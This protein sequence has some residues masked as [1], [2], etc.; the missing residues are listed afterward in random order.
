MLSQAGWF[1]AVNRISELRSEFPFCFVESGARLP[2]AHHCAPRGGAQ[3]ANALLRLAEATIATGDV[4]VSIG[5][6]A[7]AAAA[8]PDRSA[9]WAELARVMT[10]YQPADANLARQMRST[11]VSAAINAYQMSRSTNTRA[12]APVVMGVALEGSQIWRPA[13]S[14][15]RASLELREIPALRATYADLRSRQGF[16]VINTSI[17]AESQTPRVCVQFSEDLVRGQDY[18]DFISI[19]ASDD[20]AIETEAR[21]ICANGLSHG[22]RYRVVLRQGLPSSVGESLEAPVELSLY[23]RDRSPSARFTGSNFV[24]A[25]KVEAGH[26]VGQ[27]QR[28]FC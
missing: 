18:S 27:H 28:A 14:A 26:P 16:R 15:Y 12:D 10:G 19:D 11:A 24:V 17:D 7:I 25:G 22:Q 3:G 8:D 21:Q 23:V 2:G 13:L 6:F 1:R 5:N 20:V 9:T 4:D